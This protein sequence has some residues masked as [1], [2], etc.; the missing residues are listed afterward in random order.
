MGD[1]PRI[2]GK[3]LDLEPGSAHGDAQGL[4]FVA[5]GYRAS[6]VVAQH[7]DWHTLQ[8]GLEHALTT[9]VEVVPIYQCVHS[10]YLTLRTS[11]CC[12]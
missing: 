8:P 5:S 7:D 1:Q 3:V 10:E 2:I 12:W 11:L 4:G 6:V 9:H